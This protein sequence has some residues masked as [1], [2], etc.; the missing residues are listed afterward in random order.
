MNQL[1]KSYICHLYVAVVLLCNSM[2]FAQ[3]TDLKFEHFIDD[4]G[5]SQNS[6][7]KILQDKEGFL[8]MA[9]PNG[10]YKYNGKGFTI[11]RHEHNNPNSLINN[12][13]YELELDA[14][15]NILIGTGRGLSRF[16]KVTETFSTYPAILKDKR[17]SAIYPEDD[18]S[19]WVGTLYSGVYYFENTDEL[20]TRPKRYS[21]QS[22]INSTVKANKV[23]SITKDISGNVWVGTNKS[24]YKLKKDSNSNYVQFKVL[25][26]GVKSLFLDKNGKLWVGIKG[27]YL[28]GIENAENI[29]TAEELEYKRY[30]FHPELTDTTDYGG[31]IAINQADGSN[32]WLGIHGFGLYWFNTETGDF[33]LYSPNPLN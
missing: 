6:V 27:H 7:M 16:N 24:L 29:N 20:G 3:N 26:E 32:L 13:V 10:L 17:I 1:I 23:H 31:L 9:T 5:L 28:I 11:Y 21:F 19:L 4:K 25:N 2:V 18:G 30:S 14:S 15:G 12:S 22:N 8:W 33:K